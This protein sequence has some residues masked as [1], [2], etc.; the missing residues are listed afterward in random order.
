VGAADEW[1]RVAVREGVR[2][3][4]AGRAGE[5]GLRWADGGGG[6]GREREGEHVD[7]NRPR[8]EG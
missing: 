5:G 3:E 8:R 7:R 1:G 4:R 2:R 6:R